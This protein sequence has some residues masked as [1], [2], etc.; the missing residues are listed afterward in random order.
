MNR[1]NQIIRASTIN[2]AGNVLLAVVKG[3]TGTLTG[4]IAITL[5]AVNSL[6]DAL[7]SVIAIIG[8]KLAGKS[9]DRDH[10]FGY[11][12]IEYLSSIVIAALILSAGISSFVEA[13]RSI[14]H[15]TDPQ[16][17]VVTILIVAAAA[18]VKFG[19]GA[20]LLREG[21]RLGSGSLI[22]SG[23]DS[24]MDGGVSCATCVAGIVY[25][26]FGWKVESWLAA[27]I[28]LLIIK[29]GISLLFETASKLLG[30]RADPE[31]V[32]KVE[33]EAQS[34]DKV[35]LANGLVLQDFGPDR[36]TGSIHLTVDGQMS[37]AEFDTVARATQNRVYENCGV[38]LT[39]V[40]PYPDVTADDASLREIRTA[41]SHI[42]WSNDNVVDLRG[43]YVDSNTST[44]RFDA[45][46]KF[47]SGDRTELQTQ[48]LAACEAE[49]PGWKF[50]IRVIPEF[51]D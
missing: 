26:A 43:L 40:T 50:D 3:I 19:L 22:G 6:A 35:K 45:I 21:K 10:P 18:C 16:Y 27:V 39:G 11:G 13:L 25:M 30:E 48:L 32:A 29:G 15:P 5:D 1:E 37:V 2:I 51:G 33:R 47:G 31:I 36:L 44:V 23:T 17:S 9:A 20:L 8:T 46:V 41:V 12:R 4:S 38:V 14:I 34:V 7:S 24:F 28:A 42:V 49:C